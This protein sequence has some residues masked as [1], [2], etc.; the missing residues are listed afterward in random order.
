MTYSCVVNLKVVIVVNVLKVVLS[1]F[2]LFMSLYR[3]A[4][5]RGSVLQ[6]IASPNFR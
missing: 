6:H 5:D 3:L 4:G 1:F 2:I